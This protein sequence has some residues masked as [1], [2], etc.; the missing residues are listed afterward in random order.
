VAGL[1]AD[2]AAGRLDEAFL[3]DAR[4]LAGRAS[5]TR[6]PPGG[7]SGWSDEDID[8]LVADTAARVTPNRLILAAN[9]AS[10]D[11]RF[12]SYLLALAQRM[13]HSDPAITLRVYG[14]VF[15]GTQKELSGQLDGL[16]AATAPDDDNVV[17]I[18]GRERSAEGGS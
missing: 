7:G 15:E 13:G 4:T 18:R 5:R 14:H 12:R 16:R 10:D 1:H 2:V 9:E 6:P 11:Q 3:V 17:P 8:D